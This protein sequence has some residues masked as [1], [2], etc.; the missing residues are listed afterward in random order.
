MKG[1]C[2]KTGRWINVHS[3][4]ANTPRATRPGCSSCLTGPGCTV[5]RLFTCRPHGKM[6]VPRTTLTSM[7]TTVRGCWVAASEE[8]NDG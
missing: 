6:E 7:A 1:D 8:S 2:N 5:H 3:V 4:A